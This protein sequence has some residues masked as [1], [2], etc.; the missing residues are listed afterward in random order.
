MSHWDEFRPTKYDMQRGIE[1]ACRWLYDDTY[2]AYI[3]P[4][5]INVEKMKK[6]SLSPEFIADVMAIRHAMG[7]R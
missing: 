7:K 2:K 4:P 3:E 1:A 5:R 6:S